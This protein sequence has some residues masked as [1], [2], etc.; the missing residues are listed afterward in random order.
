MI[1]DTTIGSINVATLIG[2]VTDRR[3]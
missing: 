1:E 2:E 3:S